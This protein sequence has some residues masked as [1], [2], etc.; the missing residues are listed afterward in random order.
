VPFWLDIHGRDYAGG[1]EGEHKYFCFVL[2]VLEKFAF[3][4]IFIPQKWVG[5]LETW[6]QRASFETAPRRAS[7][8]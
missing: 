8:G 1:L 5:G 7:S 2:I 6:Q 3:L 4:G